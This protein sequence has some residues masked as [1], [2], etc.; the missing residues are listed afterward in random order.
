MIR[1]ISIDGPVVITIYRICVNRSVPATAGARFVVSDMGDILSPKYAPD[2]IEP[3]TIPSFIP[4][5]LPIPISAIPIVA[6]VDHELPVASETI[7]HI[8]TEA[9]R[10]MPGLSIFNP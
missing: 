5:A 1:V 9:N 4:I 10:K 6:M 8:T 3:A 2:I 7:E